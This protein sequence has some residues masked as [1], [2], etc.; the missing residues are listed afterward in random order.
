MKKELIII[1]IIFS[2]LIS[3]FNVFAMN[4]NLDNSIEIKS[5][6]YNFTFSEASI[7]TKDKYISVDLKEATTSLMIP[8]K[9][10][11][12]VYSKTYIFP[13]GTI[14]KNVKIINSNIFEK[15]IKAKIQPAPNPIIKSDKIDNNKVI[16]QEDEIY[17]SEELY[18]N[19][20]YTYKTNC[21]RNGDDLVTFLT[22]HIYPVR[23]SP[24]KNILLN[25]DD[26]EISVSYK[27]SDKIINS[28]SEYDMVVIGPRI[29]K[30]SIKPLIEHKNNH[31]VSTF[32]KS[33]ESICKPQIFGGYKGR[34]DAEKVKYF[35]KNAI[36]DYGIK[37]VLFIG[38]MKGQFFRWYVP[39]RYSHL[40][41]LSWLQNF[42]ELTYLTDLYFADIYKEGGEFDDWDSNGNGIFAEMKWRLNFINT[43]IDLKRV[44]I[45]DLV[46][47]VY[48][49][50]IPCRTIKE[51]KIIV[52]KIIPIVKIGL[53]T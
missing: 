29:F 25:L 12:P 26:I 3:S 18:P 20:W 28:D 52:N 24:T 49:G 42:T 6:K 1:M 27:E 48:L 17:K 53:I 34:D 45:L 33:T 5:E 31:G 22:I 15:E 41:D 40:D 4:I 50:R 38:G 21:G 39:V 9:P 8:G 44:D 47:D 11:L 10:V 7:E 32:F 2:F 46:P 43:S 36:E 35:I 16:I 14:I 13:F 19:N 23:Y 37:Y 30:N 51:V